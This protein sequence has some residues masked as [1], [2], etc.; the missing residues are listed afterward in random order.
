VVPE[1]VGLSD[2]RRLFDIFR[3]NRLALSSYPSLPYSG[4]LELIRA[5]ASMQEAGVNLYQRWSDLAAGGVN[6][7]D[8]QGDHYSIVLGEG[9]AQLAEL[10]ALWLSRSVK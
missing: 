9:A 3:A 5:T 2:L 7:H 8:L 1:S 6:A 4:S 10:L